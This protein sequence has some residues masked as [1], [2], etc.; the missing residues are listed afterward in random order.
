MRISLL[1][2]LLL[3]L[4]CTPSSKKAAGIYYARHG[5]G[6]EYIDVKE[7]GTYLHY[8]KNDSIEK[9]QTGKWMIESEEDKFRLTFYDW[10]IYTE[11]TDDKKLLGR[12]LIS[13][14]PLDG[15]V[16]GL[17][18]EFPEYCFYRETKAGK[19]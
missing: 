13:S 15:N 11:P 3:V 7:E 10:V 19:K 8:F 18:E 5:K 2:I 16:I 9:Q 14:E 1:L 6:V 17:Q 4:A 12:K